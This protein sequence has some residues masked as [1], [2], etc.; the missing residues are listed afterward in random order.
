MP[1]AVSPSPRALRRA[2]V[3]SLA[4]FARVL[5]AARADQQ[6]N[7]TFLDPLS[8]LRAHPELPREL[9][10][11]LR[12]A[13]AALADAGLAP[14]AADAIARYG[15]A[16][17]AARDLA[18][19]LAAATAACG[20]GRENATDARASA[21]AAAARAGPL[22][23]LFSGLTH[24]LDLLRLSSPTNLEGFSASRL[25]SAENQRDVK[26][27]VKD[28]GAGFVVDALD[29]AAASLAARLRGS[30]SCFAGAGG[31]VTRTLRAL[32]VLAEDLEAVVARLRE[33]SADELKRCGLGAFALDAN[34]NE[35]DAIETAAD[36]ATLTFFAARAEACRRRGL[37]RSEA[38][39]AD[40]F[41]TGTDTETRTR[42]DRMRRLGA[43][44]L[45]SHLALAD[46]TRF[47]TR[48]AEIG[49]KDETGV[50]DDTGVS[51]SA[52][53]GSGTCL[54]DAFPPPDPR[55]DAPAGASLLTSTHALAFVVAALR[56][57][58]LSESTCA[59][60][61]DAPPGVLFASPAL[62]AVAQE[63]AEAGVFPAAAAWLAAAP[64]GSA[65]LEA[66]VD[67]VQ[68]AARACAVANR[69][70]PNAANAT[71]DP[72]GS[73][74]IRVERGPTDA[75]LEFL[76][77]LEA[78]TLGRRGGRRGYSAVGKLVNALETLVRDLERGGCLERLEPSRSGEERKSNSRESGSVSAASAQTT[79]RSR[80]AADPLPR[81]A[82]DDDA[83][84]VARK[85]RDG[86]EIRAFDS[87][88]DS[89]RTSKA[90]S[91]TSDLILG[92]LFGVA[93]FALVAAAA[94]AVAARRGAR[95]AA[96]KRRVSGSS[97]AD[98]RSAV[99]ADRL[100]SDRSSLLGGGATG[101]ARRFYRHLEA[102]SAG[103]LPLVEDLDRAASA[104]QSGSPRSESPRPSTPPSTPYASQ[105]FAPASRRR[106]HSISVPAAV[107]APLPPRHERRH[108]TR[109]EDV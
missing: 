43:R 75:A 4:L 98:D 78:A 1:R 20:D 19:V 37:L 58:T 59:R 12:A 79:G 106:S 84:A 96:R 66:S 90:P 21:A 68:A 36:V 107:R 52:V 16:D 65:G 45:A 89:T 57:V 32:G 26:D 50:S 31:V 41:G 71:V 70:S 72:R 51:V 47:E 15:G 35:N 69:G 103:D 8:G 82:D 23:A 28:A 83:A 17:R 61:L 18:L 6:A 77:R 40:A 76:R 44:V 64:A 97:P 42:D 11:P 24:E 63:A 9:R 27:D 62:D 92:V 13:S 46:A 100:G 80:A 101:S 108:T 67:E 55:W 109:A 10:L 30:S 3:A 29:E 33:R 60:A 99:G 14:R 95:S 87:Q 88:G 94:G 104:T 48:A 54:G 93:A 25:L 74:W 22:R 91:I 5:D 39:L 105:F 85:R 56:D 2:F 7:E 34:E 86:V 38:D 102:G 49:R 81:D 73:A 53:S